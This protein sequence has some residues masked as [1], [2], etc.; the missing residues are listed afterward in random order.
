MEDKKDSKSISRVEMIIKINKQ[1]CDH[2]R[3]KYDT[4]IFN[5]FNFYVFLS[6]TEI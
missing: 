2:Q 1:S 3:E 6:E 4:K 5:Y